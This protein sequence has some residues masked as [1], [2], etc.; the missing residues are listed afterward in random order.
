MK[1][2]FHQLCDHSKLWQVSLANTRKREFSFFMACYYAT[3]VT[4]IAGKIS[5]RESQVLQCTC[6]FPFVFLADLHNHA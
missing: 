4:S 1:E 5:K 3:K 6:T 2:T